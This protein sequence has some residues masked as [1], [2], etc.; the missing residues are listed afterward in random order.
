MASQ[1]SDVSS[2][3]HGAV[4]Q[5]HDVKIEHSESDIEPPT[6]RMKK[7]S[8][9]LESRLSHILSCTVSKYSLVVY[10]LAIA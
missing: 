9:N 5:S 7:E 2:P 8:K 6:K 10:S 4:S 1:S 3:W